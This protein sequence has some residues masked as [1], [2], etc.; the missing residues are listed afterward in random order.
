MASLANQSISSTYDG[1][2]KTATDQPVPASGVQLLEDGVGN[3]LALSVG[4][5]GNGATI[6][7]T[8]TATIGTAAQPNITS[9]GTLSSLSV[10]GT[11]LDSSSDAGTSGQVLSSTGTGT[12]WIDASSGSQYYTPSVISTNTNAV[13][14]TL[15]VL[16]S[17]V[18]LT[19]P[20][21]P[22]AGDKVAVSNMSG[23]TTPVVARN[24]ENIAGLAEDLTI[25]VDNLG[26][27]L[28]Y[29]GATKG[30]VLL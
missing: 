26:I 14:D 25:D 27:Q 2:V 23:T 30:W 29:T 13:V 4:R 20:A 9:L 1:L 12:N 18:T 3:T 7:G 21:S 16:T 19:L 11:I 17:S 10:T 8:L 15:Y 6:T 22:S 5:A 24:G 28:V